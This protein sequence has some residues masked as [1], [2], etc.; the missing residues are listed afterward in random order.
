M[1]EFIFAL[2]AFTCLISLADNHGEPDVRLK[3]PDAKVTLKMLGLEAAKFEIELQFRKQWEGQT[4]R[5]EEFAESLY[6]YMSDEQKK[7]FLP[8]VSSTDMGAMTKRVEAVDKAL[9]KQGRVVH[10]TYVLGADGKP[11]IWLGGLGG[12]L[13]QERTIFD[14][15]GKELFKILITNAG[16]SVENPKAVAEEG[17]L[18]DE[19]SP[20]EGPRRIHV[21]NKDMKP[22]IQS[23]AKG[24]DENVEYEMVKSMKY[25]L[26]DLFPEQKEAIDATV[27]ERQHKMLN[28][29]L[30][31]KNVESENRI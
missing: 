12:E 16:I 10:P 5:A 7:R 17:K 15:Q 19:T 26:Y 22:E 9:L 8:E 31:K 29:F 13:F 24:M 21:K 2:I 14:D 18:L 11:N 6:G 23:V 20:L 4:K 25:Y 27:G 1:K 3:R 28:N 30:K